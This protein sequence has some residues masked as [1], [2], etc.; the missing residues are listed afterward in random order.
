MSF[1]RKT[2][3][4][5]RRKVVASAITGVMMVAASAGAYTAATATSTSFNNQVASAPTPV[6]I[7]LHGASTGG[8]LYPGS[9][10][11]VQGFNVENDNVALVVPVA[12][13]A[14]VP[15]SGG[16]ALDQNGNAITGC[17][18]SWFTVTPSAT[19]VASPQTLYNVTVTAS[20]NDDPN[21]DQQAC[22]GKQIQVA[23]N[24]AAPRI[25]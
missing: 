21:N 13:S 23:L 2:L 12:L 6:S 8:P 19:Q 18:A 10:Q 4:S 20:L 5:R 1:V 11:I 7:T 17:Y 14:S 3:A 9:G 25:G 16:W 24:A 15:S 22:T